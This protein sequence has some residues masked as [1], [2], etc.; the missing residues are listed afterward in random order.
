VRDQFDTAADITSELPPGKGKKRPLILTIDE[1]LKR[2]LPPVD[3]ILGDWLTTTSRGIL[4]APT[5]IGKTMFAIG[6]GMGAAANVGF[7]H[8]ESRRPARTLFID[9][10]MSR[11]LLKERIAAE[12]ERIGL[13]AR[14][15]P[16]H[17][18]SH[19]DFD[20]F[21]PLNTPAG[22]KLVEDVIAGIG[23]LDLLLLDN[24]MSLIGGDQKEEEGWK[25]IMP[26]VRSLTQRCIGQFWIHHTGH[27]ATHGYGTKTREWP[28]D[29]VVHLEEIT[30]PETDVSFQLSFRKAR[31]R[32]PDNRAQFADMK[33]ALVGDRWTWEPAEP[34]VR[35]KPPS[36]LAI[37]FFEALKTVVMTGGTR[38]SMEKWEA[39]CFKRNLLD[40]KKPDSARALFSKNKLALITANWIACDE[41]SV[42]L[43]VAGISNLENRR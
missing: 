22:R 38:A 5:G 28:L 7:L 12:A 1:W 32:R 9:G 27:D 41:N 23:G 30:R 33:V 26:W 19:E 43:T 24:V 4:N 35:G 10:E 14:G 3:P 8:W 31:E 25:Q 15:S 21:K 13:P 16:M 37:K 18:L 29:T 34:I 6:L 17:F 20:D 40:K 42:W 11:R 36:P 39:V 2:A